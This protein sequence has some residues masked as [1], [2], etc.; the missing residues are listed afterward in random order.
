MLLSPETASD[1]YF[2]DFGWVGVNLAVPNAKTVWTAPAGA[3]LTPEKPVTLT[4]DNGQG[5]VFTRQ[6]AVDKAYMFT[7]TDKLQN[8]GA[9]PANLTPYGVVTRLGTPKV[10][11][12][13]ILHEGLI[14][15]N[16]ED[17][18]TATYKHQDDTGQ[19]AF[20]PRRAAGSA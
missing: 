11:G 9:S 19:T 18:Q 14:G 4:Y 15:V 17:L 20:P 10:L 1:A 8:N 3:K 12:Y 13:Y 16:R 2:A 7:I 5:L 6:I